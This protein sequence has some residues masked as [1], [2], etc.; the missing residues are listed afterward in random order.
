MGALRSASEQQLSARDCL[1]SGDEDSLNRRR[2]LE[3]SMECLMT[4]LWATDVIDR[5]MKRQD[6][7]FM[8][9]EVDPAIE[10]RQACRE[11][12]DLFKIRNVRPTKNGPFSYLIRGGFSGNATKKLCQDY[13]SLAFKR[14]RH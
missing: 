1:E 2:G 3:P 9:E 6:Q 4:F 7:A 8:M 12:D 13:W 10:I 11:L 5:E 14:D